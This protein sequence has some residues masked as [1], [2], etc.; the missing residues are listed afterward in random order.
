VFIAHSSQDAAVVRQLREHLSGAGFT[1]WTYDNVRPGEPIYLSICAAMCRS[2]RCLL[3]VTPA[4]VGSKFFHVELNEALDRQCRLGL[5]FCLPVYHELD[6]A[7]R[8]DQLRDM[9]SLDYHIEDL[10]FWQKLETAIKSTYSLYL[11]KNSTKC[12]QSCFCSLL[13]IFTGLY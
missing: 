12:L 6:P 2:R 5:V 10:D 13:F 4:F 1:T 3:L 9:P 8:P 11:S 7:S